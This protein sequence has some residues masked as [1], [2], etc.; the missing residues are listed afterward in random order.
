MQNINIHNAH[1]K[2]VQ[3][4]ATV[5]EKLSFNS[6]VS[7]LPVANHIVM[8]LNMEDKA[9]KISLTLCQILNR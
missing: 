4:S 6:P 3:S 8:G 9:W 1:S 5:V 7:E 2:Q